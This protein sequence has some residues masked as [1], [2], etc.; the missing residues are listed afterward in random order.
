MGGY[1][2]RLHGLNFFLH[3]VY[4]DPLAEQIS[5]FRRSVAIIGLH[6]AGLSNI[7]HAPP[8]TAVIELPVHPAKLSVYNRMASALGL[9]YYTTPDTAFYHFHSI[10]E[11]T[12]RMVM[13]TTDTLLQALSDLGYQF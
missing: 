8:G 10:V 13:D 4:D 9:P 11:F 6:G 3:G 5:L 7:I 1:V 12:P 2:S